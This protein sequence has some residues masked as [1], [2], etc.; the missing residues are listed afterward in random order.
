MKKLDNHLRSTARQLIKFDTEEEVLHYLTAAFRSELYCDFVGVVQNEGSQFVTKAWS[1]HL[2]EVTDSFPLDIHT[3][4]PKLLHQSLTIEKA[5]SP[6]KCQMSRILKKAKVKTW[7]TVPLN[8]NDYNLG[9]CIVGFLNYVP[10][11]EMETHF[12]EFGKDIAVAMSMARE[13][14]SQLN[15]I[16]GIEWLSKNLSLNA[17]IEQQ[18]SELTGRAGK[19]TNADF[20]CI[21][22]IDEKKNCFIYQ[23]PSY[24]DFDGPNKI[25]IE[26]DYLL[27]RYFPFL[28]K[29]GGSQLTV[30][31]I[32]DL[33]PI[34]VLHI[35][36]HRGDPFTENDQR[37]LEL[38]SN[39]VAAII[40]NARLFNNEKEQRN[41]LQYLLDYQQALVKETVEVENFDGI[42]YKLS[43]LFQGPVILLDRFMQPISVDMFDDK[44]RAQLPA[45]FLEMAME[46]KG[47]SKGADYFSIIVPNE[48]SDIFTLWMINGGGSILGYLALRRSSG[49][50][51][52]IDQLTIELARN[53]CSL[54]FIKQKLVLDAKEQAK[55]SFIAK[56]L[57]EKIDDKEDI[58]QYANLF[59]WDPFLSQRVA[60]IEITLDERES[61]GS[62]LLEQIAKKNLVWD[63]IKSNLI[64]IDAN[65]LCAYHDEKN[66][67]IVPISN[68]TSASKKFWF[69]LYD[70]IKKWA[71]ETS[72]K[73]KVWLGIGGKTN[74]LSDYYLSY[75]QGIQALNIVNSRLQH[76]GYSLF[77]ELGSYAILHH[78]N[79][80]KAVDLF[81]M[82]QLGPLLTYSEG[83]NTDL[84][85]TLHTFLQNNGNVK[86]TAEE[87]YIHRSSLL[88]RLERIESLLDV[89]LNDA[90]VRFNLMMALKLYDMYGAKIET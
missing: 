31:L 77:E 75:Q 48:T 34:G 39:H 45:G 27:N 11:L 66:I 17:P 8:D 81:V 69:T 46:E 70:Q 74:T 82:K 53:I 28:E 36:N 2:P 90:E 63:Y 71:N 23:P 7:F 22:L 26:E 15:K 29:P 4:S 55:D 44:N 40:E 65:I 67:L 78:L 79:Y 42:T 19:G 80:S 30:P 64:K 43:C 47:Y 35:E 76:L 56:L 3:C 85:N 6:E 33:K 84:C 89:Q 83:R 12:E 5:D 9:F 57:V 13:K 58:L 24:G 14:K 73:C 60:V 86:N 25:M 49:Y 62:N 18:I 1:G 16:E 54:Q 88:Y 52:E 87:L 32:I 72:I 10:L 51:D 50:L 61:K 68:E 38:L 59:Q 41:R 20:A 37:M 21:Y